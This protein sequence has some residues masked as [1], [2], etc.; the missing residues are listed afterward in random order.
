VTRVLVT[1][2]GALADRLPGGRAEVDVPE[3]ATVEAL[4]RVLGLPPRVCIVVVNGAAADPGTPLAD[5]DRI[6]VFPPMAGG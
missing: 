4:A 5:G 3:P 2:K 1:L 6:Q